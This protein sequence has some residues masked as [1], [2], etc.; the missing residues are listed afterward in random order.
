MRKFIMDKVRLKFY[1]QM[2]EF[3]DEKIFTTNMVARKL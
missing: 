3:Q 2:K 1:W